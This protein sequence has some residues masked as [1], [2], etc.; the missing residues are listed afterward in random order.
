MENGKELIIWLSSWP[1]LFMYPI[2]EEHEAWSEPTPN[3]VLITSVAD[4][5]M[6]GNSGLSN[7]SR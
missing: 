5:V 1:R 6:M 4:R 2:M 3:K 7:Y